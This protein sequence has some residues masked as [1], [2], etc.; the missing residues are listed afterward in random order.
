MGSRYPIIFSIGTQSCVIAQKDCGI[1]FSADIQDLPECLPVCP[2]VGNLCQQVV[3][4]NVPFHC[5][6]LQF[7]KFTVPQVSMIIAY[8]AVNCTDVTMQKIKYH[9]YTAK[10]VTKYSVHS[11]Y[12]PCSFYCSMHKTCCH[13]LQAAI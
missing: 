13:S 1:L 2:L 9:M 7:P 5:V 8:T 11:C 6:I 3:E 12:I 10:D 4:L